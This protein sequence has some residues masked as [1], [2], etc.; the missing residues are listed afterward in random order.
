MTTAQTTHRHRGVNAKWGSVPEQEAA[1]AAA[2]REF[3]SKRRKEGGRGGGNSGSS[4]LIQVARL[5]MMTMVT[6]LAVARVL[7]ITDAQDQAT[8]LIS[9]M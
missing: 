4:R 5:D 9:Q 8:L 1:A 6:M 3:S 2:E 7:V